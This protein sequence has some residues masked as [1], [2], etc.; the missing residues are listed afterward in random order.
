MM[1]A[2]VVTSVETTKHVPQSFLPVLP[3][4]TGINNNEYDMMR[5]VS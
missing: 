5:D 1:Q 3:W 2:M 4:S